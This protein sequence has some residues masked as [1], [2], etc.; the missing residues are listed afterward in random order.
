ML[1]TRTII[2]LVVSF[3][4]DFMTGLSTGLGSGVVAAGGTTSDGVT[5][6]VPAV[7]PKWV[8]IVAVIGGLLVAL[9]GL[10][11]NLSAPVAPIP[12]HA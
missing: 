10:Q 7:P 11:K 6:T 9:R 4:T 5:M 3:L 2:T 1:D 12:D 8:W